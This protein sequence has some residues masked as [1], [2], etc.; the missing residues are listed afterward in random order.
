[1]S[2][3]FRYVI[4]E[5]AGYPKYLFMRRNISSFAYDNCNA[6][7]VLAG[8]ITTLNLLSRVFF[9]ATNFAIDAMSGPIISSH[10]S[11]KSDT[12]AGL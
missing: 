5:M 12:D 11:V 2:S 6:N 9:I 7:A 8:F 4:L 10:R 3:Y 1:M